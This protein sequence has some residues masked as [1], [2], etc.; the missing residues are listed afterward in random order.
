MESARQGLLT[1]GCELVCGKWQ[2]ERFGIGTAGGMLTKN[3]GIQAIGYGSGNEELAHQPNEYVEIKK[4]TESV[5]GTA[6]I[7]GSLIGYPVFG[8]KRA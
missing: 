7:I 2:I 8:I 3:Y 5:Y 1:A 4:L 6:A